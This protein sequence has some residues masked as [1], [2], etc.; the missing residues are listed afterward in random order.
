MSK[1]TLWTIFVSGISP[2]PGTSRAG[3]T[4]GTGSGAWA[5]AGRAGP[6]TRAVIASPT[7]TVCRI[8]IASSSSGYTPTH[9]SESDCEAITA[10]GREG[11]LLPD[12]TDAVLAAAGPQ[13]HRCSPHCLPVVDQLFRPIAAR[14]AA[15]AARATWCLTSR[16]ATLLGLPTAFWGLL[17]YAALAAISFVRR[18][19]SVASA[20][21]IA[22]FGVSTAST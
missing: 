9:G 20:W 6:S 3:S 14:G 13:H 7:I 19:D 10:G 12:H 16:W 1:T 8:F 5:R 15:R 17:A 4:P 21:T 2:A 18:A 22:F 11:S